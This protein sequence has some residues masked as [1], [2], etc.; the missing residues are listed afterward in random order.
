MSQAATPQEIVDFFLD[1]TSYTH[2]VERVEQVQTHVSHLFFAGD[3]VYKVKK[4][5]DLGFLDFSTLEKRRTAAL[6]ELELNRR[7]APD[8]YLDLAA[9]HRD[10]RGQLSFTSPTAV[11]EVAVV[12]RR[13]PDEQRLSKLL[14]TGAVRPELLL[15]LGRLVADFHERAATS[16]AI[17]RFGSLETVRH[18]WDENFEQTEPFI[19]R[20]LTQRT[21][22]GCKAEIERYLRV[23]AHLFEQRIEE[24]RIRDCHGDLQ[25]DDIFID[26]QSGGAQVLDCIEFNERFRYSD[27]LADIAFLS[28]DLRY[29]DRPDLA[30]AFLAA[31]FESSNDER[32]PSLLRFYES[33][34]AYVRGKVRSFVI[35]QPGPS[36]QEKTTAREEARRFFDL[37]LADALKL[38]PRLVLLSG[39]MG[40]GKTRHSLEL[41]RRSGAELIH[42]DVLRK[43]L[44]GLAPEEE[45]KVPFA[46]G[47]YS[48]EW[49]ERTYATLIARAR[50]ELFLGNSVLLDASWSKARHRELARQAAAE[51]EA[52]FAIVE[53]TAPDPVL[54]RRLSRPTRTITDGRLELLEDQRAA[55]EAPTADEAERFLQI[56]TSGELG[57]TAD[58]AYE[59]LFD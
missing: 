2:Q 47:I 12:M 4:P 43:Q 51:R 9:V 50:A 30:E 22:E 37:S 11:E 33:Y 54:H 39:L 36:P 55:F 44:A 48:A 57:R 21:W 20:T 58:M 25:A 17:A 40:S 49:T 18:N 10:E 27:T 14:E 19:G 26:P 41:A 32:L 29:R 28:M 59:A 46:S 56:D 1:P 8:V 31:Y 3:Y 45:Q 35:D 7:A 16:P 13:L 23:Y 34:R 15:E 53:C 5:V 42:S 6:A 38:R 52:L 24:G